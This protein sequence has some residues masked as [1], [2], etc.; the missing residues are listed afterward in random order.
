MLRKITAV[1]LFITTLLTVSV[2]WRQEFW[3]TAIAEVAAFILA[4]VWLVGYC[5]GHH[6]L[7]SR[8]VVIA[9]MAA[10]GWVAFQW[11]AGLTIYRFATGRS[12]LYWAAATSVVFV[13]LQ[14]FEDAAVRRWY[15]RAIVALGFVIAIISPLQLYTSGGRIFWLF[16]AQYSNIAMGPFVYANQYAAFIE[17]L[18]PVALVGL[19]TEKAGWRTFYG[20]AAAVM[21][22]SVFASTSRSGLIF[23]TI[24]VLIVPWLAAKRTGFTFRQ[25]FVPGTIFL[26]MLIVMG[27]AVGPERMIEK[28]HQKDPYRGRLEFSRSAL[29]MI[30]DH[31]LFG[32][33]AGNWERAYPAYA[34]FDEGYYVNQAHN[35]WAQWT[36][37]GGVPF[38]LLMISV[39]VWSVRRAFQTGWGL[40]IAVVLTQCFMDYPI[41]RMGVAILFFTM[42]AAVAYDD[43]IPRRRR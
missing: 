16:E 18:L 31:P 7:H 24:E 10:V 15:L 39:A 13:G 40:G 30:S 27:L 35:D 1:A 33:G 9:L 17:L 19:L 3:A 23:T 21:Y 28:L 32:I 37:E 2:M 12:L 43:E 26:A 22:S 34:T 4:A 5:F 42:V 41:Q 8:G 25:A 20:L 38:L 11:A 29:K 6:R 36:V 14:V